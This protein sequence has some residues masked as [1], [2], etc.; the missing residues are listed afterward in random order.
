MIHTKPLQH[1][2]ACACDTFSARWNIS[3]KTHPSPHLEHIPLQTF[4][5]LT[6]TVC[7]LI[8]LNPMIDA[9][10]SEE[11]HFTNGN[12]FVWQENYCDFAHV[13]AAAYMPIATRIHELLSQQGMHEARILDVGCGSGDL[14]SAL[15]TLGHK[16][17]RAWNRGRKAD[18][19]RRYYKSQLH[20][21]P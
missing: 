9:S 4:S 17:S 1:C 15:R 5:Y 6:C 7:D 8:F 13:H 11:A 14:L 21:L 19:R 18:A 20:T 10:V 3:Y 16:R 12:P 2:P